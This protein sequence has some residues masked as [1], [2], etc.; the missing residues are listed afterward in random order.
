MG[1]NAVVC[2]DVVDFATWFGTGLYDARD[3]QRIVGVDVNIA[4][5]KGKVPRRERWNWNKHHGTS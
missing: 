2:C 3:V 5:Q 1:G 4:T